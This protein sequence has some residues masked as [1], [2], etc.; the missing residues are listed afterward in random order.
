MLSQKQFFPRAA[1]VFLL[2]TV[3]AFLAG[4]GTDQSPTASDKGLQ[5]AKAAKR[6][7]R[8]ISVA[9][10][11]SPRS[12]TRSDGRVMSKRV[13]V[14]YKSEFDS[15]ELSQKSGDKGGEKG[16]GNKG[17]KKCFD[18][19]AKG[20][21]WKTTEPYVLDPTNGDG[22]GEAFVASRI[23]ASLE[24]WNAG[25]GFAI[26]GPR[27][28]GSSVDGVDFD[29]PDGKNEVVFENIDEPG[30]IAVTVVWGVFKGRKSNRE[31]LEWDLV[32][33]I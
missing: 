7:A 9:K 21:R 6:S 5:P 15:Q 2:L 26:F 1:Q 27:D 13:H 30:V 32:L 16:K 10:L 4:C 29:L 12:V 11:K 3:V 17:R 28:T 8:R 18:L 23:A 25:A 24:T 20:A 31:L 33:D 19:L 14:F 22:L